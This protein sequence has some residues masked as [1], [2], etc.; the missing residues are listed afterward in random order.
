MGFPNL[1][2]KHARAPLYSPG[3][4]LGYLKK[5]GRYPEFRAPG[6]MVLCYQRSL[7][8]YVLKNHK[9]TRVSGICREMYLLDETGGKAAIAGNFGIGAPAAGVVLEELIAFGVKRFISIGTAGTLQKNI[10]VGDLMVCEKAIRDEG[11]SHHYAKP[12]KYAYP[13]EKITGEIKAALESVGQKYFT[14]VTWTVDAPYRETVAEVRK[15]QKEGVA[16]VEMEA[17]ALFAIAGCRGAQ[18][19]A[20]FTISDSLAE[21]EWKPEFHSKRTAKGLEALYKAALAVL[22]TGGAPV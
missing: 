18:L 11:T 20:I 8:D 19:G 2:N 15:Y 13:S 6:G 5:T 9:T 7:L 3:D 22:G 1:K 21:L 14:G 17:S 10:K 4:F 12:S 16:T